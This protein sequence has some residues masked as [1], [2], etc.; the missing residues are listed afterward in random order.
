MRE[1]EQRAYSF[2]GR[3]PV[4]CMDMLE[5]L[6]RGDG[7][8]YAVSEEGAL[9]CERNSRAYML[10]AENSEAGERLVMGLKKPVQ[11]AVH[12][13]AGGELFRDIFNYSQMMECWAAAYLDPEPPFVPSR[14]GVRELDER[15]GEEILEAFPGEFSEEE[16]FQRLQ[17]GTMHGS[18]TAGE[19]TGVIGLY[20]EGGI[21]MLAV[22]PDQDWEKTAGALVGHITGWCLE[23]CFAPLA[24]IPQWD[25]RLLKL[26]RRL[27]YTV[28]EKPLCWLGD[29]PEE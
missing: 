18:F 5:A 22:R 1:M 23:K 17:S 7:S 12:G 19:L 10:A 25:Q 4:L 29:G 3:D 24:H 9:I 8:V 6:R 2:L 21:G 26:Y 20:P 15:F 16:I 28:S 14:Y 27:G 11:L 13:S